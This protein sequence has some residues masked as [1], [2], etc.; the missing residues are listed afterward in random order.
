MHD[1]IVVYRLKIE[2][3]AFEL[4]VRN[5]RVHQGDAL[6]LSVRD[7][8]LRRCSVRIEECDGAADG[9]HPLNNVHGQINST[10]SR[11]FSN[12]PCPKE[13]L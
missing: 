5:K 4:S 13:P 9:V 3:G 1:G 8:P 11:A 12:L 2:G 7:R 10:C 6:E